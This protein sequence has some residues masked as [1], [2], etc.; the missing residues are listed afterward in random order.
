MNRLRSSLQRAARRTAGMIDRTPA[1]RCALLCAAAFGACFLLAG[2]RLLDAHTPLA[3][4]PVCV[5]PFGAPCISAYLGASAGY[6]VFWGAA[7][8]LEPAAAGFLMLA[9]NCLFRELLPPQRKALF[10]LAAPMLYALIGVVFAA[11]AGGA[12]ASLLRLAVR[13]LLLAVYLPRLFCAREGSRVDRL[14]CA[15]APLAA[16][17]RFSVFPGAPA[18]LIPACMAVLLASEGTWALPS[19][20]LC[21][22]CMDVCSTTALPQTPC[23]CLA[24]ML[25]ARFGEKRIWRGTAFAGTYL[26]C[27]LFVGARAVGCFLAALAGCALYLAVPAAAARLFRPDEL[28]I[29][30][31]PQTLTEASELLATLSRDA[32]REAPRQDLSAAVFDEAAGTVC[33]RCSRFPVC[34]QEQE[35]ETLRAF[36]GA[37]RRIV[38]RGCAKEEDFP[39]QFLSCCLH[40]DA[41]LAAIDGAMRASQTQL[42]ADAQRRELHVIACTMLSGVAA[43]LRALAEEPEAPGR[44]CFRLELGVRAYSARAAQA[45]GDCTETFRR[46]EWEYLL[47]CDGMGTGPEAGREAAGAAQMLRGLILLGMDAQ[48]ALQL[49]NGFYILRGSGVFS[50]VDLLQVSL[51]SGEGYLHKWGAAPSFLKRGGSVKKIGTAMMPPGLGV[52]EAHRA[53]C[54]R[55]SLQRGEQLVLTSDGVAAE[56]CEQYLRVCGMLSP[57]ELAAGVAACVSSQEPDDRTAAVVQLSPVTGHS[58]HS[59]RTARTMSKTGSMSHI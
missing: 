50:T 24:A 53:E 52:G 22:L 49:L 33:E 46:G 13:A 43:L 23:L 48:D 44:I 35:R 19:A 7:D 38:L 16:L 20:A 31:A 15:L 51:A 32:R 4:A 3:L 26:A 10:P 41:L 29:G 42:R 17:G 14:L 11:E 57:R 8:A 45:N 27:T 5:I 2:M 59:T 58:K 34:W 28:L 39:P 25:C 54:V 9:G 12:R 56:R 18:A 6:L 36:T 1:V 47:L 55:L 30:C 40:P 21:G 37:S